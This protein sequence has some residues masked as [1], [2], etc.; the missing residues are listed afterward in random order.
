[1]TAIEIIK[2]KARFMRIKAN[3]HQIYMF[4]CKQQLSAGV[5]WYK[6]RKSSMA[7]AY[8][9]EKTFNR[10]EGLPVLPESTIELLESHFGYREDKRKS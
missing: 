9:E 7:E 2:R 4:I 5:S 3:Q 8:A 10:K 6:S 1:M